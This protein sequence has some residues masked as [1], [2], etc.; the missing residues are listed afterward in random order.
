MKMA[1]TI[2]NDGDKLTL[3]QPRADSTFDCFVKHLKIHV[4]TGNST[5][6]VRV[7]RGIVNTLHQDPKRAT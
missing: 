2:S 3:I 1:I 4:T 5:H 6:G 7:V